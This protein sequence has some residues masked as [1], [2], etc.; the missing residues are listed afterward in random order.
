MSALPESPRSRL[1]HG[2]RRPLSAVERTWGLVGFHLTL[3]RRTWR[4]WS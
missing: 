1:V 2:E 4:G 3:L